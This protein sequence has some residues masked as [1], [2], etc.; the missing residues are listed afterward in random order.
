MLSLIEI[1]AETKWNLD[2]TKNLHSNIKCMRLRAYFFTNL[3]V[4]I[5]L[6]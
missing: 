5:I 6:L 3:D 1:K 4:E 2:R